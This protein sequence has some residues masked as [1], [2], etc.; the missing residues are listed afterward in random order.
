MK[1]FIKCILLTFVFFSCFT[2][3]AQKDDKIVTLVVSGQ[4]KTQE[5]A[6][7]SA[8]RSAVEQAFGTFISSKTEILNDN[9]VKD[10]IVSVSNGNIQKFEIIAEGQLPGGDFRTSL[11]ATVSVTKLTTFVTSKGI[12]HEL[13]GELFAFNINQKKLNEKNE[14]VAIQN[15]NETI[16]DLLKN[17]FEYSLTVSEPIVN[18]KISNSYNIPLGIS[19]KPTSNIDN[20]KNIVFNTLKALSLNETEVLEYQKIGLKVYVLTLAIDLKKSGQFY[21]RNVESIDQIL[22]IIFKLRNE[23]LNF[24]ISNGLDFNVLGENN[25]LIDI[26]FQDIQF[27]PILSKGNDGGWC[28]I[29]YQSLFNSKTESCRGVQQGH[30]PFKPIWEKS[31]ITADLEI[32]NLNILYDYQK[33]TNCG[34]GYFDLENKT[35]GY[36]FLKKYLNK[37][38]WGNISSNFGLVVSLVNLRAGNS[39]L[40]IT[41]NDNRSLDELKK[42]KKYAILQNNEL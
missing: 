36:T 26:K 16:G 18:T 23:I 21:Y 37:D 28:G 32:E 14:K 38:Q 35:R 17:C 12:E 13:Q 20:Y 1:N 31:K 3:T 9:L 24:K 5:E 41:M 22:R 11:K 40:D 34:G 15:L 2:L 29:C 10:E 25:S 42:I 7:Q 19:V 4:G 33:V 8:L 6:K 39:I 27:R 30:P